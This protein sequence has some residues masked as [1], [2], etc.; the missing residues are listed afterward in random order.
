MEFTFQNDYG[1]DYWLER[2]NTIGDLME[3]CFSE[4][5]T[6][7]QMFTDFVSMFEAEETAAAENK[8]DSKAKATMKKDSEIAR[9]ECI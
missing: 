5:E 3:E 8:E 2:A 1:V 4:P 7:D 9:E 6:Q